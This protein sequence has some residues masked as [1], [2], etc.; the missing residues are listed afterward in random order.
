MLGSTK[1]T[2][3]SPER[4][5]NLIPMLEITDDWS[6]FYMEIRVQGLIESFNFQ[7]EN[8]KNNIL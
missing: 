2:L 1:I 8:G 5:L 3:Q 7:N 6:H 4:F